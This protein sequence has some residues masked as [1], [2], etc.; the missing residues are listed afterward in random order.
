MKM[1][2]CNFREV[3]Q[4]DSLSVFFK[5]RGLISSQASLVTDICA[6]LFNDVIIAVVT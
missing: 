2:N 5:Q 1:M 3:P 6:F 4:T